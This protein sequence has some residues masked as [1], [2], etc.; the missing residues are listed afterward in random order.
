MGKYRPTLNTPWGR[1]GSVV[2]LDDSD[3][4]VRRMVAFRH[5]IPVD[6]IAVEA[7]NHPLRAEE[8]NPVSA[9]E[10]IQAALAEAR[11]R[12]AEMSEEVEES[13]VQTAFTPSEVTDG[14]VSPVVSP[15]K[16]RSVKSEDS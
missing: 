12:Q 11:K 5:L 8:V 2:V 13:G 10:R 9:K 6:E 16:G 4:N 7:Q 1:A 15:K 14:T 3:P